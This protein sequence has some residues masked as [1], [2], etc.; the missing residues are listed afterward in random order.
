VNLHGGNRIAREFV[1]YCHRCR[2]N[3]R[4][5]NWPVKNKR[6]DGSPVVSENV[7]KIELSHG[8]DS[9]W[10]K[11]LLATPLSTAQGGFHGLYHLHRCRAAERSQL[12]TNML[13]NLSMGL[14]RYYSW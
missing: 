6:C 8:A 2:R 3:Q 1:S 11:E 5:R 9:G 12:R 13:W 7:G 10:G 14:G 4:I